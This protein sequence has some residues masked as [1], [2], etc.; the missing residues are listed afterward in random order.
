MLTMP[1]I[2]LM[3]V[4][5]SLAIPPAAAAA[6]LIEGDLGGKVLRIL[7]DAKRAQADVTLGE[8]RHRINLE[9]EEAQAVLSDGS[10]GEQ[11]IAEDTGA[12]PIPSIKPWGPG[13]MVAGHASVY[14][15]MTLGEEICG[16]LLI[17]PW[18]KPFV[19]PA[20][21]A[22]TILERIKGDHDIKSATIDGP[23]GAL[24]FSSYAV[25]GWPLMAGGMNQR[26]FTTETISFDYQPGGNEL[27]WTR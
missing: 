26:L 12:T 27:N 6:L 17:S 7:V 14:H 18:M 15:V 13:P 20:V 22:L 21:E 19:S 5:L 23:C 9:T 8:N 11:E 24:P 25:A 4:L 3:A 1:R 2:L 10:L 16:E